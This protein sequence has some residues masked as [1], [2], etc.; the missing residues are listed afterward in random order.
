[1]FDAEEQGFMGEIRAKCC[2]DGSFWS[3]MALY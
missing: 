3:E 2:F 1:V